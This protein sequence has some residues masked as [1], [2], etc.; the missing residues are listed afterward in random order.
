[1]RNLSAFGYTAVVAWILKAHRDDFA[2]FVVVDGSLDTVPVL[3]SLAA[4]SA[5]TI[6]GSL[7]LERV[8]FGG[9]EESDNTPVL[10]ED[11]VVGATP[12]VR[13][14]GLAVK[15][16]SVVWVKIVEAEVLDFEFRFGS[17]NCQHCRDASDVFNQSSYCQVHLFT[18]WSITCS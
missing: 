11:V 9:S 2:N 16:A 4:E 15:A 18:C 7:Q 13:L 5:E 10:K 17:H 14:F 1:M 8:E 6:R 3:V 12:E